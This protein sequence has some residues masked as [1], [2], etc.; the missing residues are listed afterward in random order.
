PFLRFSRLGRHPGSEGWRW[1]ISPKIP[2]HLVTAQ[3]S[4]S[5][6]END[7]TVALRETL[8]AWFEGLSGRKAY[9]QRC[10]EL[11]V[12][13]GAAYEWEEDDHPGKLCCVFFGGDSDEDAQTVATYVGAI[14]TLLH[15]LAPDEFAPYYF[16]GRFSLFSSICRGFGIDL[17]EIP[18]KQQKKERALYYLE[19]NGVLQEFRKQCQLSPQELNAFLYDFAPRYLAVEQDKELPTPQRVWF[20][21]AGVGT[22]ADFDLLDNADK[23]TESHWRGHRDARRGDAAVVWCSSP[24]AYLHSIWRITEDGYDDPFSYWYSLVR[25]GHPTFVPHLKIKDLKAN[26]VLAT[27]TMVRACFQ[28]CAGRYFR[29]IDYAALLEEI[30]RRGMDISGFPLIHIPA[31]PFLPSGNDI[32]DERQVELQ[33]IE[34]LL[35]NKLGY[36]EASHWQRQVRVRM[37]RGEKVYPDYLIGYRGVKGEERAEIVIESKYRI[38]TQKELFETFLQGRSYALRL[39]A[40]WLLLASLEG[41][42]LLSRTDDFKLESALHWSWEKLAK[43]EHFSVLDTAI[44]SRML[45]ISR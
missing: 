38:A 44:G 7:G 39:Q 23:T 26:P 37:G 11:L 10:R 45:A 8:S 24:R 32:L 9:E 6:W 3:D 34:P 14:S 17:P 21:M 25:I 29:P 30:Q 22:T 4:E 33:L 5:P 15:W 27:S 20:L 35:L 16:E 18:G 36:H 41:I 12:G 2:V 31:L 13:N 1:Q 28:G 42:W 40:P 43:T 19:I